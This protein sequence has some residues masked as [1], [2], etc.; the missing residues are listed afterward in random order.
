MELYG[1]GK[2]FLFI[3]CELFWIIE[4]HDSASILIQYIYQDL[5]FQSPF[6]VTYLANSL[7]V[8]YLPLYQ[9]WIHCGVVKAPNESIISSDSLP[10]SIKTDTD[11]E[12]MNENEDR[13]VLRPT[14]DTQQYSHIEVIKIAMLIS[15]VWFLA[16]C[17]YNYSLLMTSNSSSTIIRSV[18]SNQS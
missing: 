17:L 9:L 18:T 10:L 2:C 3:Q 14:D 12:K 7:L 5:D 1:Q 15:P 4:C 13:R 16:N 8:F 6:L 11:L